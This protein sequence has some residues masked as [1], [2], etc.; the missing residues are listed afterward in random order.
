M[1]VR[2]GPLVSIVMP[3]YN[4]ARWLDD[5]IGSIIAQRYPE[6]ELIAVDDGSSDDSLERLRRWE[7]TG[8]RITVIALSENRGIGE[9]RNAGIEHARGDF[10]ALLDSDDRML[11]HRLDQQLR[12]FEQVY[13][14]GGLILQTDAY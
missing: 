11:P 7:A 12:D 3:N 5:A 8:I 1:P 10:I 14:Q 6:W 2:S 9:A 4:G 13:R